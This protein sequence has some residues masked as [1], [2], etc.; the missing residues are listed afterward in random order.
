[1][2]GLKFASQMPLIKIHKSNTEWIFESSGAVQLQKNPSFKDSK[3]TYIVYII[4]L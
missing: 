3:Y 4:D 1:M 2:V